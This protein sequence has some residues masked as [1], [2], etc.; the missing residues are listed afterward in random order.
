MDHSSV[1][2]CFFNIV[3]TIQAG[4]TIWWTWEVEDAFSTVR[5]GDKNAMKTFSVKLTQQLN[6]LVAMVRSDLS[7]LQRKKVNPISISSL[8]TWTTCRRAFNIARD[9]GN[10]VR[11]TEWNF[12]HVQDAVKV[13]W[14]ELMD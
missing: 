13:L 6:D 7:N 5:L 4:S 10:M 12:S 1:N 14:T 9:V 8:S 2:G 11:Y 3:G